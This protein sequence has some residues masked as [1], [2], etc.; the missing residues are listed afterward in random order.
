MGLPACTAGDEQRS[1]EAERPLVELTDTAM[2]RRLPLPVAQ[3]L[4]ECSPAAGAEEPAARVYDFTVGCVERMT[5]SLDALI[6]SDTVGRARIDWQFG[7]HR[8]AVDDLVRRGP[9]E[10]APVR[11]IRELMTSAAYLLTQLQ[12]A[13]F[14]S[15]ADLGARVA[16][17]RRAARAVRDDRPLGEQR[18]QVARFFGRGGDVLYLMAVAGI[19]AAR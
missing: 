3:Y 4:A 11:D 14:R 5:R 15:D 13:R 18:E 19:E 17:L 2:I 8:G 1:S 12:R 6:R 10:A 7:A 9:A 16:D